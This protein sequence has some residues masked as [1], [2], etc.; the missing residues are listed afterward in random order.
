[1]LPGAPRKEDILGRALTAIFPVCWRSQGSGWCLL[2]AEL[3]PSEETYSWRLGAPAA[4]QGPRSFSEHW[5]GRSAAWPAVCTCL[6][7]KVLLL[8]MACSQEKRLVKVQN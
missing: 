3:C 5:F 8:T 2:E 6:V 1:M 4:P 7:W